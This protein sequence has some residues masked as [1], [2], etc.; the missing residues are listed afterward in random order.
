[1]HSEILQLMQQVHQIE[2]TYFGGVHVQR[3][4]PVNMDYFI[5]YIRRRGLGI[6]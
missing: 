6:A 2:Y 4:F 3:I 5:V 1:M